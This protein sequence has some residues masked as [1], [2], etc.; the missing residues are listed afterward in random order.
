[1]RFFYLLVVFLFVLGCSTSQKVTKD[2]HSAKNS[3]DWPGVYKG[4]L[5]CADCGGIQTT[6]SL[7]PDQ[8]FELTETYQDVEGDSIFKRKG[9][10]KWNDNG[11]SIV[12][13][14]SPD[15][16][17]NQ[18]MIAEEK[19]LKLDRNG[20]RIEGDLADMFIL[21]KKKE[22]VEI[23]NIEGIQWVLIT[24]N[25]QNIEEENAGPKDIYLML[26]RSENRFYGSGGCNSIN[27]MYAQAKTNHISFTN[28]ASTKMACTKME[29]EYQFLKMLKEVNNY[30]LKGDTLVLK[31]NKETKSEFIAK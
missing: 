2:A 6:L 30:Q 25:G 26:R 20:K 28:I 27:G 8:S 5:P 13:E 19:L 18:Y 29:L 23:E 22:A 12:L 24:M 16:A 31:K 9:F 4:T 7:N 15:P 11:K 17:A 10:F 21:A 3:L 1:M 14:G